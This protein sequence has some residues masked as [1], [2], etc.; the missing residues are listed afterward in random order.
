MNEFSVQL[1]NND[2]ETR[3]TETVT[4]QFNVDERSTI[5]AFHASSK[6]SVRLLGSLTAELFGTELRVY[7]VEAGQKEAEFVLATFD[8][9]EV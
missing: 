7:L 4:A 3:L 2:D 5:V 9:A 6:D 1:N 8:E